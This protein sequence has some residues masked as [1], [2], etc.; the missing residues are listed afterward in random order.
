M[1]DWI[2]QSSIA[3]F[4]SA[5]FVFQYI[6]DLLANEIQPIIIT[7]FKNSLNRYY[8]IFALQDN[9]RLIRL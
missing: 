1:S 3:A 5:D 9:I 7:N 8:G 2:D 6:L 4:N